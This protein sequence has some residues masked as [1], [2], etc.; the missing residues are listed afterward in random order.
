[1][2]TASVSQRLTTLS[3]HQPRSHIQ[4]SQPFFLIFVNLKEKQFLYLR[5]LPL[6]ETGTRSTNSTITPVLTTSMTLLFLSFCVCECRFLSLSLVLSW[7]FFLWLPRSESP[8]PHSDLIRGSGWTLYLPMDWVAACVNLKA[9][10]LRHPRW[11]SLT[12]V[13]SAVTQFRSPFS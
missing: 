12:V 4:K 3:Q 1:M 10:N 2:N 7:L 13:C 11:A 8:S 9:H 6:Q 5:H